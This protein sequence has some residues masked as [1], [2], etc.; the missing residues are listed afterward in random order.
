MPQLVET[1]LRSGAAKDIS[2]SLMPLIF[3]GE[4]ANVDD[5][6]SVIFSNEA[7]LP[8]LVTTVSTKL[9]LRLISALGIYEV[10][11]EDAHPR[12]K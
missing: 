12:C 9:A 6:K 4:D 10:E 1:R 3:G 5:P 8:R 2:Q 7:K 11:T